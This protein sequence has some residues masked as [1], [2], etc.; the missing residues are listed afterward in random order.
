MTIDDV[1]K[2]VDT[3]K[4]TAR[5]PKSKP[6]NWIKE[7]AQQNQWLIHDGFG[8]YELEQGFAPLPIGPM[9]RRNIN[10]LRPKMR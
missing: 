9:P 5:Q 4:A 10:G 1:F 2:I 6:T 8:D 7:K 3:I